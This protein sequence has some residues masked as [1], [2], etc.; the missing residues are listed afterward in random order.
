MSGLGES[1]GLGAEGQGH[2]LSPASFPH[3]PSSQQAL[4]LKAHEAATAP[5][6][7]QR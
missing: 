1:V 5:C 4:V 7:Q 2:I 6:L 3:P